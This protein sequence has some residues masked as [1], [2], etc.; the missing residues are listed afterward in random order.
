MHHKVTQGDRDAKIC[1]RERNV[2]TTANVEKLSEEAG[3][4]ERN[5]FEV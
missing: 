2:F 1:E 4:E 3:K 5:H